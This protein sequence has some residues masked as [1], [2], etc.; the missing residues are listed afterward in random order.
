MGS[1]SA[2][3][4]DDAP[5]RR[6]HSRQVASSLYSSASSAR[7]TPAAIDRR[8]DGADEARQHVDA[9]DDA[10]EPRPFLAHHHGE[11]RHDELVERLL[12]L[13]EQLAHLRDGRLGRRIKMISQ[14][15]PATLAAGRMAAAA[16]S[17]R[18]A[19]NKVRAEAPDGN[20]PSAWAAPRRGSTAGA[21]APRRRR[22]TTPNST[23][24]QNSRSGLVPA[25]VNS[26][27]TP[28]STP[29]NIASKVPT[30]AVRK[31]RA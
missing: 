5:S 27:A 30:S 28:A 24:T 25:K 17:A 31:A 1:R 26:A 15:M 18:P 2:C 8:I 9:N 12:Q 13:E 23:A 14:P 22:R 3:R 4:L 21:A 16:S 7:R 10:D 29:L 6:P 11:R 20:T 19:E